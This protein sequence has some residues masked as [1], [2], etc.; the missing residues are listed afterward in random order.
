MIHIRRNR[1]RIK[2]EINMHFI[3]TSIIVPA[4]CAG[5]LALPASAQF[6]LT[7]RTVD[8]GVWF[9][10]KPK[11]LAIPGPQDWMPAGLAVG[12]YNNDSWPDIFWASG[13]G[14]EPDRLFINNGDGTFT[15]QAAAWGVQVLHAA[16]GACAGDYND[17]GWTDIYVTS[18][19]NTDNNQGEVGKNRLYK[20]NGDGTFSEV[21]AAAGVAFTAATVSSGYG[22]TFGDYDIDGD[23][24]LC[25]TAWFAPAK[26]NRLFRN[27]GDGTF[28]NVTGTD[29][30]FPPTT[31]GF[32]SRFA[33][34]DVD[35]WPELLIS[36]DFST[37]RYYKNNGDG[38]FSDLTLQSGTGLDQNGMG[39][40]LAD[41]N[42]DGLMDWYVTSIFL[43]SPQPASGEGNKLYMN[44]GNH[45]YAETSVA[46]GVDNGGWG[47]GTV[48]IDLD[49]DTWPDLVEVNGRPANVEF[50]GEQEYVWRNNGDGTFFEQ[51]LACGLTYQAEGKSCSYLDFDRDGALD[52]AITFNGGETRLYQNTG[53]KGNWIHLAF[54]TSNN[55]RIAPHGMNSRITVR[56]GKQEY[57][58]LVDGGPNFEGTS[59]I[60]AHFGL[61]R[62]RQIDEITVDWPRGYQTVLT[63]VA[64]NQHLVIESPELCD[65]D[66]NGQVDG[67]DLGLLLS[68]WGSLGTSSNR[69]ADVNNDG[70]VDG[71][72]LGILL[73]AWTA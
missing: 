2:R 70:E 11:A 42:H 37:S 51:A 72:D 14:A 19:G 61:G 71:A 65:F 26:G 62:A 16:C 23:L 13:G 56:I 40:S 67:G 7:D 21:A 36:A 52:L 73:S 50:T 32:Q 1:L 57:V 25:A 4:L 38:T 10:H 28:T 20:N 6:D 35:G 39:Q 47:W 12:D 31:W 33:D 27:N 9:V 69:K 45:Q 46:S 29:I 59:E 66:A 8:A 48:A 58:A 64:V 17:D 63:N 22:C 55:Q 68:T 44:L 60:G 15:D 54:D 43:D 53:A 41:F 5:A 34:M 49:H 30:V 3:A 24:D 18:F